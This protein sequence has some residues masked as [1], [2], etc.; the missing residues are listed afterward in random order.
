MRTCTKGVFLVWLCFN[1][2]CKINQCWYFQKVV[3]S[4]LTNLIWVSNSKIILCAI[5]CLSYIPL[6]MTVDLRFMEIYFFPWCMLQLN[7][8]WPWLE[9]FF[10]ILW[11]K[12]VAN[13]SKNKK[14]CTRKKKFKISG[15]KRE[16]QLL[17]KSWKKIGLTL[18]NSEISS[19]LSWLY[20]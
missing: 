17:T 3:I 10:P 18:F 20:P 19:Y 11:N 6:K 9:L 1:W 15:W 16:S 13:Y 12:N 2:K 5:L 14:I 7:L 8:S 4:T